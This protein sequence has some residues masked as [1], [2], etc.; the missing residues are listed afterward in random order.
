[1][2]VLL[3]QFHLQKNGLTTFAVNP[4]NLKVNYGEYWKLSSKSCQRYAEEYGFDYLLMSPTEDEWEPWFIPEPQFDQFRAI[5]F[6]KDYDAVIFVDTDI[7]IKP[8]SPN[9]VKEYYRRGTNIV[10]N[11][12]IGN[13][14]LHNKS[15]AVLAYNTGVVLYYKKSI[16][17]N[18]LRELRP[19]DYAYHHGQFT[20]G[21]F[22][23]S[24]EELRWWERLEDFKPFISKCQSGMH[25]DDKFL[26]LLV[27]LYSLSVSHLDRKFN[28]FFNPRKM[29]DIFSDEVHFIHYIESHKQFI[30]Q[31][32]NLIMEQ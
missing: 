26:A 30:E 25:N 10:V 22:I 32:Y 9:I 18:D 2:K 13:N 27:N 31:H 19:K 15:G 11:T 28:Y 17:T 16:N 21:D 7:I 1:M 6:L 5:D 20:L 23:K 4:E 29:N 12:S 24:R 8:G 3:Y 14:L